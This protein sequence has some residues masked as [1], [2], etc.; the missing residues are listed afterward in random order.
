MSVNP[1]PSHDGPPGGVPSAD[2]WAEAEALILALID[3]ELTPAEVARL[4]QLVCRDAAVCRLYLKHVQ[5]HRNLPRHIAQQAM[6]QQGVD[7]GSAM[8]LPALSRADG[9]RAAGDEPDGEIL[10]PAT[11]AAA[12]MPGGPRRRW[13]GARWAA[14]VL[15]PTAAVVGLLVTRRG[16]PPTAGRTRS[17]TPPVVPVSPAVG[18]PTSRPVVPAGPAWAAATLVDAV[19]AEWETVPAPAVGRR[20][21]AG[22]VALRAG[23]VRVRTDAGVT[24]VAQGPVRLAVRSAMEV[25]LSAGAVTAVVPEPARG[26]AVRTPSARAVDLG[27]EFGVAVR[28]DRQTHVEVF[29]GAVRASGG[30]PTGAAADGGR[31]LV[32]KQA[33]DVAADAVGGVAAVVPVRWEPQAFVRADE[34]DV[35]RAI[36]G[37][38]AYGRWV[39]AG[40]Q[41]RHDPALAMYFVEPAGGDGGGGDGP[42]VLRNRALVNTD[43]FDVPLRPAA[44]VGWGPGRFGRNRAVTFDAARSPNL[45]VAP[46]PVAPA[47]SMTFVAWVNARTRPRWASIAK[48]RGDQLTGQFALGLYGTDG[49]LVARVFQ[50]GGVDVEVRQGATRPLPVGRWVQVAVVV[51]GSRAR[52]YRDG[53]EVA[54]A[55]CGPVVADPAMRSLSIGYRTGDDGR[56]P[57]REA[58]KENWDGSMDELALFHRPLTA[59]EVRRM[60]DAGRPD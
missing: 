3:G 5:L 42:A 59:A 43:A 22:T 45:F 25:E 12:A 60:Y 23:L 49:D 41:L 24:L 44:A 37:R 36:D 28:P 35:R 8:I 21:P 19:R 6:I 2:G 31:T 9:G 51:D 26:F 56:E 11:A 1:D 33:V 54:A 32:R 27:T 38:L 47:G 13:A 29:R 53:A 39:E 52:L 4:D 15:L 55:A 48:S 58:L 57:S 50:P 7:L 14:A 18:E 17:P 16:E 30:G 10:R 40:Y 34:F 20:L 46:Y